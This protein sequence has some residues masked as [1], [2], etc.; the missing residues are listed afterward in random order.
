MSGVFHQNKLDLMILG[1]KFQNWLYLLIGLLLLSCS[2]VTNKEE[3]PTYSKVTGKAQGTTYSIIYFD[4]LS[5]NFSKD[6]DSILNHI[7]DQLSTYDSLSFISKFNND[8][9]GSKLVVD[10]NLF[11]NCFKEAKYYHKI[12]NG[13]FNPALFPLVKY[14]GFYDIDNVVI[15][16]VYIKDSLLPIINFDLFSITSSSNGEKM[17]SKENTSSKLDFN[18]IA[19]GYSVDI[20]S[21]HLFNNG[22]VNYMVEIGGEVTARGVNPSGNLWRIGIERPVDDSFTGQY[23]FQEVITLNNQAIATSGSYRK[24]KLINGKKLSH[25]I[26]PISGFPVINSLLS[27]TVVSNNATSADALATSLMVMGLDSAI[28]FVNYRKDSIIK[29]YFIYDSLGEYK[30]WKNF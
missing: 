8:K 20:V 29:A 9:V 16:T 26:N 2:T 18:A 3:F 22:I 21:N 23:G 27:V 7:D 11:L 15:D 19:Q 5:R 12:T 1:G 30:E 17:I 13:A 6:F 24:Y 10:N 14:W 4:S 28:S 25:T